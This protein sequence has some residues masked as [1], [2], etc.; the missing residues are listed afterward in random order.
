MSA[1]NHT[2]QVG[3]RIRAP[4][5]GVHGVKRIYTGRIVRAHGD[6]TYDVSLKVP[7]GEDVGAYLTIPEAEIQLDPPPLSPP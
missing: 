2:A 6:R 7:G 4:Y 5:V 3:A 1:K